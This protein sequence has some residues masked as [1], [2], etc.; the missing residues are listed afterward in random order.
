MFT[1]L[2]IEL[3]L[4]ISEKSEKIYMN[5]GIY[6]YK[7]GLLSITSKFYKDNCNQATIIGYNSIDDMYNLYSF[8][9]P[10]SNQIHV[11]DHPR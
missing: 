1:E 6:N 5:R 4:L 7:W 10:K 9:Y 8:S 11:L 2:P 3:Q